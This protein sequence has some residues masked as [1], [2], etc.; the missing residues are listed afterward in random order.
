MP[1]GD[2]DGRLTLAAIEPK[3]PKA[4]CDIPQRQVER[5]QGMHFLPSVFDVLGVLPD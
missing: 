5:P 2:F 3:K 1:L 4:A